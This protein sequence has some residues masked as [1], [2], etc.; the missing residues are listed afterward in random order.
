MKKFNI[1]LKEFS[2]LNLWIP[3]SEE[4]LFV[5]EFKRQFDAYLE[6]QRQNRLKKSQNKEVNTIDQLVKGLALK[7]RMEVWAKRHKIDD[8]TVNSWIT[9]HFLT[10]NK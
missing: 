10:R 3:E 6:L 5:K 2:M 1:F 7:D 8:E 4:Q 9:K